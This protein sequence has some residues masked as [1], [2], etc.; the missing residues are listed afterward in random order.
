M[1]TMEWGQIST[2]SL[3]GMV[4]SLMISVGLPILLLVLLRKKTK[5]KFSAFFIGCGIFVVFALVLEQILHTVVLTAT[6]TLVT[7]NVFLYALY[8]G[9]AAALFEE[10]GRLVA[11]KFL[12]KKNLNK[13]NAL[14]YGAGHG[15]I[16]AIIIVGVTYV[17]NLLTS[18]MINS[19][20]IQLSMSMLDENMQRTTF[21][22][23]R[24]LW[25][26]PSWQFYLAGV[27]RIFAIVLHIGLSVMVYQAIKTGQKKYWF[28]AF[29]LHFLVD[30][31][32]VIVS[33]FGAPVWVIEVIL[34]AMLIPI[35]LCVRKL[36]MEDADGQEE[37]NGEAAGKEAYENN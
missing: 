27:E 20:A 16:E 28:I 26:L 18:V 5:A 22:Q 3:I 7:G 36:Y 10:S 19:G 13:Q 30:F 29:G 15:G 34:F 12:M 4:F 9:L 25:E 35:I 14:M 31:V 23:L 1:N 11:M 24:V 8:G 32:T 2:A 33:G 21:E 37:R 17:S 6:G